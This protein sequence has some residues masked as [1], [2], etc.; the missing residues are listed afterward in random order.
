MLIKDIVFYITET[1]PVLRSE[2]AVRGF[3]MPVAPGYSGVFTHS[4]GAGLPSPDIEIKADA[5]S[6]SYVMTLR[7]IT[8]GDMDA[9]TTYSWGFSVEE[10]VWEA[11]AFHAR[12]G[13][14][15]IDVDVFDRE[16]V[17]QRFW[18]AQRFHYTGRRLLDVIDRMLWDLASRYACL[19]IYKLLGGCREQVPAYGL[20]GGTTIDDIVTSAVRCR[21]QGFKGG[22][23]HWYRGVK[24]NIEMATELRAA[25]GKGFMLF[26]D[27]VESYTCEEAIRIGRALERLQY[28]WI[29][30][31]LQDYDIMSLRKLC[32]ALDL[33][34]LTLE[35]IGAIGGQ[36]FNTAP[37]LALQAADIV[38]QRGIGITGQ[39]KQ[40][41]LAESFGV[42]VHGGDPHVIL[43]SGND[44]V[45]EAYMGL[46]PRPAETDLTCQGTLVVENGYMSVAWA[47][48][49]PAEPDWDEQ[50]RNAVQIV[51][52]P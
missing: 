29:E 7:L 27:P 13:H 52:Q 47:P 9:Y 11:H 45:F 25:M 18:M 41:Q 28:E 17:W 26:H 40:A 49:H 44:P 23:D 2:S 21:E 5:P 6:R 50:T 15:L 39:V 35:W 20:I 8:D 48:R 46:Q 31:P 14:M 42:P 3:I 30:E 51:K 24:N 22:K 38:R 12:Y 19:P 1:T 33:P 43:A 32:A 34:V 16:L 10:L 4:G 37:Y 36:P